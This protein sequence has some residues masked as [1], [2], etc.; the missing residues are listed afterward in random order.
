MSPVPAAAPTQSRNC[1]PEAA[2]PLARERP[3]TKDLCTRAKRVPPHLRSRRTVSASARPRSDMRTSLT[4]LLVFVMATVSVQLSTSQ[5]IS[6]ENVAVSAVT[7]LDAA[8][9]KQRAAIQAIYLVYCQKD[10]N[11]GS[12]FLLSN[13]VIVT[14]QHVVGT[15]E[16]SDLIVVSASNKRVTVQSRIVDAEK[17][18]AL[19]KPSDKLNGGLE[20][21]VDKDPQPGTTVSTWGYPFLYNGVSP[22]LSVGYVAGFKNAGKSDRPVKHIIVNGAF[23]HGNSGGPL[24]VAQDN[25][26][27]GVVVLT[28]S[29]FPEYVEATIKTLEEAHGG[30][31]SGRFSTTDANGKK[32][33]LLDQQVIGMMLE[34][35]YQKT[36]V[37]IGEAISASEL[38]A[39][40][41]EKGRDLGLPTAT[42]HTASPPRNTS[43]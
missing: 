29:F 11:A 3:P 36:Q 28:Y 22:L 41:A 6:P 19:L 42:T 10:K 27:I 4:W 21:A 5:T 20:L 12:G 25:K 34:E 40:L 17:D 15:C 32:I 39:F 30:F 14:N 37:M 23:N 9:P 2:E 8:G 16:A 18:L 31:G 24:L 33:D 38:R 35:F 43:P 26:V 7:V 1:H 13:G